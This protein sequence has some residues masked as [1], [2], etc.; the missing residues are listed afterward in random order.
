MRYF[1]QRFGFFILSLWAAITINFLLPRFMP[2]NPAEVMITRYQGRLNPLVLHSLELQFGISHQPL[3]QQY[4]TYVQNMIHGQFGLSITYY[5]V[6]VI[7]VIEN[8]LPWTLGLAGTATVVSSILGV[9]LGIFAAWKRGGMA[10]TLLPVVT[11]FTSAIPYQWLALLLLYIFGFSLGWFPT[12]HS[13]SATL[14]P[15]LHPAFIG[16]VLDHAILPATT[17]IVTALGGWLLGMRNNMIHTLGEDY[18]VF[19]EAKGVTQKRL[20]YM[21]AARNAMLPSL[22]G[23][24][25]AL[26]FVVGG[27][28]LVES[29]FSYPGIGYQLV[30]A[31]Q[32]EDYPLMQGLFLI[33]AVSVLLANFIVEMLY[34]KLD[35]RVKKG[36]AG[37]S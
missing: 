8:S 19:A 20:K 35:P 12:A 16:N 17:M 23:F 36:G 31:V 15:S 24:G 10:D 7:S 28:V 13:Y 5:P 25:M 26:G 33:I 18:V 3:W 32:N 37:R 34:G 22:T 27:S 29:V 9:L 6:P 1:A 30:T 2:G 4:V 11:T 21:Y 14:S